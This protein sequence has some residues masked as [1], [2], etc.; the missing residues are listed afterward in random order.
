MCLA[1]P[2]KVIGVGPGPQAE[3]EFDG[4][5]RRVSLVMV[6][7][8]SVGDYVLVRYGMVE[9]VVSKQEAEAVRELFAELMVPSPSFE[10][11]ESP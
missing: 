4:V 8:V 5:R 11:A 6:P 10:P 7:E 9:E 2:G 3:A 1:T